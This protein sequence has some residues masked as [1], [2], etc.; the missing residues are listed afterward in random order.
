MSD[1]DGS[2]TLPKKTGRRIEVLD[3]ARGLALFA[4]A[5]YHFS[6]DLEMFRYLE[7]GI[8]THGFLKA[9]ARSIA[10]SFLLLAGVSLV[11]AHGRDLRPQAF[12]KRLAIVAGAAALISLATYFA[13]PD[14]FIFFGILHAIAACS[15]IGLAF[16][17]LP[18]L[19]TVVTGAF[20]VALPFFFR[21][22]AF[23][24][25]WLSWIGLF[26]S[27]PRSNDFVPLMP[28]LGPFLIGMGFTKFAVS[29]GL[30]ERLGKIATGSGPVSRATRFCGRHSLAFYLVHQPVLLSLVWV[31]SQLIP[32][33]PADPLPGFVSECEVGCE[34]NNGAAFCKRF[35]GCVTDQLLSQEL[36]QPFI[37][38]QITQDSD[39]RIP[40]IAEQCT[41]TSK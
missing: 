23:N 5:S 8:T 4:M 36:F 12:L 24:P 22:E 38:G 14:G 39:A 13:T 40:A 31:A 25:V 11:L 35:C 34:A 3:L 32:A 9:Y 20:C 6:W 27:P 15:V 37:S 30:T 26:T 18:A 19:I 1:T 2:M 21:S 16:L 41:A 17:R 7:P 10:G 33:T 29:R 28:W